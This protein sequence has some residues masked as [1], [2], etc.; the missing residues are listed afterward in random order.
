MT[1]LKC[2]EGVDGSYMRSIFHLVWSCCSA[3]GCCG[4]PSASPE[5]WE[6]PL[7]KIQ[8]A[9]PVSCAGSRIGHTV[10]S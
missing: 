8:K 1:D 6:L 2:L 7:L 9:E 10:V 3:Q 5:I 4:S